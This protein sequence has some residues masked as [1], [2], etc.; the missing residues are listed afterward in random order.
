MK[1]K[2]YL[3]ISCFLIILTII[4]AIVLLALLHAF[5][6][7]TPAKHTASPQ[8]TE[9]PSLADVK[10]TYTESLKT[11]SNPERGFY[12]PCYIEGREIGTEVKSPKEPLVHLRISLAAFSHEFLK[13][14]G[15]EPE[16][17]TP[18]GWEPLSEDFLSSLDQTMDHLR[19]NG[20]SA[21]IRFAYDNFE[22]ISDVEPEMDGILSH[23]QQLRPFFETNADVILAVESGFVGQYGEQHSSQILLPDYSQTARQTIYPVVNALLDVVPS[24]ISVTTRRPTYVAYACGT[25]MDELSTTSFPADHKYYRVGVF[26]DG[27]FGSEDDLGTFLDRSKEI[28]WL[29]EQAMH[30][31][32]GGE[33]NR[34]RSTDGND[35]TDG[36]YVCQEIFQTHLTYLNGEW[37]DE[38][39]HN[40]K[41]TAYNG[42]NELYQNESTYTFLENHMG[43]RYVLRS[44]EADTETNTI[45]FKIENV[46]AANMLKPKQTSLVLIDKHGNCTELPTTIDVRSW[47]SQTVSEE[48]EVLPPQAGTYQV[49][50][51]ITDANGNQIQFA[52]DNPFTENGNLIGKVKLTDTP[53]AP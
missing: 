12:S 11:L 6:S 7:D 52:N 10:V 26:N 1:K 36:N 22:G 45:H 3:K 23:I 18:G 48:T 43:Y 32:Y 14:Q 21:I 17:Y 53:T 13:Y 47:N 28:S 19:K 51:K 15:D 33:T 5:G 29:N 31:A 49:Y 34:N 40:W 42:N 37:P 27:M 24:S 38:T 2:S 4:A 41:Q 9:T 39:L 35:Y 46:G 8:F 50:L 44:F 20:S 25:T 16:N 30:T